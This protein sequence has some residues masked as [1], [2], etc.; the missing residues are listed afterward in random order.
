MSVKNTIVA[1]NE[2]LVSG[3]DLAG[4]FSSLGYNLIGSSGT[5]TGFIDGFNGDI[6]GTDSQ[7]ID[8]ALSA[9]QDNGGPTLTHAL[10]AGSR[11][12]DAGDNTDGVSIDQRGATRPISAILV[13]L[14]LLRRPS[15][16]QMSA[17]SKPILVRQ[18]LRLSFLCPMRMWMK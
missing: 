18:Y 5:A 7:R 10:L 12:I 13:P 15:I 8:P 2:A 16:F 4:A 3:F 1:G 6:V 14:K 17:R 9:L 11:A